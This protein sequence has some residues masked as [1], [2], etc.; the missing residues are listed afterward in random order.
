MN[1]VKIIIADVNHFTAD[2]EGI[3]TQ[4]APCYVQ[5]YKEHK[6][7]KDQ[8]Q[9]LVSGLLLKQYLGVTRDDEIQYNEYGK[10][11]PASKECCFNLSHSED[12]VVLAVADFEVGVDVEKIMKC[13][14]ATVKK[15][16]NDKQKEM[17]SGL[18]GVE[19]DACFTKIWTEC[20][21][22]L[23]LKGIGFAD[24]WGDIP[25]DSCQ[26]HTMRWK[27]YYISSATQQNAVI[28]TEII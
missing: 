17:L 8:R 25:V 20:E 10:P 11:Y 2:T 16:F 23:K 28:E 14:E 26:I 3:L 9:E 4:I 22:A 6:I 21:S 13:H 7:P 1:T 18:C 5:K 12:C 24:G 27:D 19:R 15:V